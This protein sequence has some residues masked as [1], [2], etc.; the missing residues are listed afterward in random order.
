MTVL[1]LIEPLPERLQSRGGDPSLVA[2]EYLDVV[3]RTIGAHPRSLQKRIGPSEIGN[4]CARR[5]GYKLLGVDECNTA[6]EPPWLPTIGTA[7]HTW[8]EDAF[9][10]ANRGLD[11]ARWLVEMRVDVGEVNGEAITGS[12]DLYDRTTATVVD[13][14]VVGP[15]ALRRYRGS[16]PGTQYRAQAHLYGRGLARRGLPVDTVMLAFLP[17]SG[18]LAEAYFWHE[19]YDEE[20][21]L[22]ALQRASGIAL[23]ASAL[24]VAALASLTPVE[25]FCSRCPWFRPGSTDLTT[26][27]PGVENRAAR[28]DQFA[29]LIAG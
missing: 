12:C 25:S 7:V 6:G 13:H 11:A 28:P 8:L 1:P 10:E 18:E 5:V 23:A 21:A 29:D 22:A 19:A 15:T 3:R 17:R 9:S 2:S 26:G 24:G 14:K 4:P 20:I 27:C 16:G